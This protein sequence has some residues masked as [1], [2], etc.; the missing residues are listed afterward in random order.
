MAKILLI[1]DD[2]LIQ[3]TVAAKLKKEGFEVI[4]CN[5]GREGLEKL[6][7]ENP[8][9]I[10]TD[11]MMPYVSGLEVVNAVKSKEG[12][13]AGIIVFSNMGQE[14][15]VEEAFELGADDYITKPFSL[16]ELSIRIKKLLKSK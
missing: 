16:S 14:N 12:N 3:K 7:K 4:S 9:V 11:V 15:I 8:D 1:E 2:L 13:T 5:D 10:L 6:E